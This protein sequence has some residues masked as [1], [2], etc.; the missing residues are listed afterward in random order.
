MYNYKYQDGIIIADID[1]KQCLI[2]TGAPNS[3]GVGEIRVD[4]IAHRL[5][6]DTFMGASLESISE[7]VG[8]PLDALIGGDILSAHEGLY[9]WLRKNEISFTNNV[10]GEGIPLELFMTIP[11]IPITIQGQE[12]Q[13]FVDTGAKQ[14]Y[15]DTSIA[16][17]LPSEETGTD[18][19]PGVGTFDV[20]L[21]SAEYKDPTGT[22]TA[23][24]K[25]GIL[26]DALAPLIAM[27][28]CKAILGMDWLINNGKNHFQVNY[29][30]RKFT[31]Y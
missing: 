7:Q 3:M 25:F 14:S 1:G 13:A 23:V 20:P 11:I 8:T 21:V 4:G 5:G 12:V 29:S 24:L 16:R 19:Y 2:D 27:A 31:N 17:D 18:Y 22:G 30:D 10:G 6:G 9:V 28:G 26:P 15:L